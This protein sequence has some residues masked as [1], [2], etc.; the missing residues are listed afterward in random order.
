MIP[1]TM[2]VE[3]VKM[4][5]RAFTSMIGETTLEKWE[6]H[7]ELDVGQGWPRAS[8]DQCKQIR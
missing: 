4:L 2:L 1:S 5:K 6:G 7:L 3:K 8:D